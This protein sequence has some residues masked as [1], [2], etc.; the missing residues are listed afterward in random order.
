MSQHGRH[1]GGRDAGRGGG[2]RGPPSGPRPPTLRDIWPDYLKDGYFDAAGNLKVEYVSREKVEPLARAMCLDGDRPRRD[3]LTSNQ[4]RRYFGHCR[5]IETRLRQSG[6]ATWESVYPEVKKLDIA[7][8][9]GLA[10]Q[11]GKIPAL[12]HDFVKSNIAAIRSKE[13]FLQG[14]LPHFEAL[15]GFG[16]AYLRRE[17]S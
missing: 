17:R 7:A 9:D 15:V 3:G 4:L 16:T 12:F 10:K 13:D 14:F 5:M 11:P 8:A 6:G 2:Y 1:G